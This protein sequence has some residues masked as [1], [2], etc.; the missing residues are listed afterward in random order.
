M[1]KKP[2]GVGYH[3]DDAGMQLA[4]VRTV[5]QLFSFFFKIYFRH[6]QIASFLKLALI[7]S[8][9][10]VSVL[11]SR[12]PHHDPQHSLE[13]LTHSR[14]APLCPPTLREES[15]TK[16]L[17]GSSYVSGRGEA[18]IPHMAL[19]RYLSDHTTQTHTRFK[20]AISVMPLIPYSS[21][22][23]GRYYMAYRNHLSKT[24]MKAEW[25]NFSIF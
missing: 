8:V 23:Y 6:N 13:V 21:L 15:V 22:T 7:Q 14:F 2:I 18:C 5:I 24:S 9:I 4:T 10:Q 1:Q 16:T 11:C 17:Q 12:I 20:E 25:K 3:N 19:A